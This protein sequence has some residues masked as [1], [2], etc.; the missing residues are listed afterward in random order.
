MIVGV[1]YSK[2]G[3][4]RA[5]IGKRFG[6]DTRVKGPGYRKIQEKRFRSGGSVH[7]LG[8]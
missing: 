1:A 2:I 4:R 7:D 8:S 5:C 6:Q 3:E